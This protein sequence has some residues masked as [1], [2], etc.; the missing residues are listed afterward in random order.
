MVMSGGWFQRDQA[1]VPRRLKEKR[2]NETDER[3]NNASIDLAL[4]LWLT[5]D[6]R[7]KDL[8]SRRGTPW[9]DVSPLSTF[10]E[11]QFRGPESGDRNS[12]VVLGNGMTAIELK[13]NNGISVNWINN[14]EDHLSY[15]TTRKSLNVYH[16]EHV[17]Q[18][19]LQW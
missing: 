8:Y 2:P 7:E 18:A 12:K 6:I 17:L 10:I 16:L 15:D 13:R 19:H 4:R 5:M 11:T 9:K 3:I 14:L 1:V